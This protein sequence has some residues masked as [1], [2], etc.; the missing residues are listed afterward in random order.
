MKMHNP[1]HPGAILREYLPESLTITAAAEA[2]HCSRVILSRVLN[3]H[4]ALS[5]DMAVK[6]SEFLGTSAEFW[7]NLQVQY[8]LWH[9]KKAKR[10]R[11]VPIAGLAA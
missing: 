8:D 2:L 1:A 9:A 7:L 11:I 3:G 10:A 5:A 4:T 6:L